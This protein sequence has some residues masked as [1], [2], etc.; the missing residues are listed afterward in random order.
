M[1]VEIPEIKKVKKSVKVPRYVER[2]YDVIKEVE[3]PIKRS[4]IIEVEKPVYVDRIV[5]K[6][7]QRVIEVPEYIERVTEV[8]VDIYVEKQIFV[9]K[10]VD[11]HVD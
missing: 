9:D 2:P 1:I 7:V 4:Q 6:P 8:P 5:K 10:Y 11:V 3:V